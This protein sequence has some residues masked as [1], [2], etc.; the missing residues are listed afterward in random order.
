MGLSGINPSFPGL[1][2]CRGQVIH[3]LL[4]RSPLSPGPKSWFSLDLHV[5]GAPPAFVLSQDQTLHEET[6]CRLTPTCRSEDRRT[7][8]LPSSFPSSAPE[9]ASR[10]SQKASDLDPTGSGEL[11]VDGID[12]IDH[13][14][15]ASRTGAD[16]IASRRTRTLLSF[17]RPVPVGRTDPRGGAT[18]RGTKKSLRLTPEAFNRAEQL[19]RIRFG[20]RRS[21]VAGR[22]SP[23]FRGAAGL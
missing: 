23:P 8:C 1:F 13:F 17:Q 11:E 15:P 9:G 19:R 22:S 5:L 21:C 6:N 7:G 12:D 3:V 20:R 14:S 4:T 18:R 10:G 16:E 2:R